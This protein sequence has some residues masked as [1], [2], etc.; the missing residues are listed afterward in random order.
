[1]YLKARSRSLLL[2]LVLPL[3][4]EA[5]DGDTATSTSFSDI[6]PGPAMSFSWVGDERDIFTRDV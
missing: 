3:T 1:M 6:M 2:V 4:D 5:G